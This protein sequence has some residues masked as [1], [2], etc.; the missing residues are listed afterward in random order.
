MILQLVH[1]STYLKDCLV[2]VPVPNTWCC[3]QSVFN[4]ADVHF[5]TLLNFFIDKL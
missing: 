2:V 4:Y 3:L 1:S 5:A